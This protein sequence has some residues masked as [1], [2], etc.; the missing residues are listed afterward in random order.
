MHA[1][2]GVTRTPAAAIGSPCPQKPSHSAFPIRGEARTRSRNMLWP[3]L[4]STVS[5]ETPCL[6]H[7]SHR[8]SSNRL[9]SSASC[10]CGCGGEWTSSCG[11]GGVLQRTS[12]ISNALR[13]RSSP[14]TRPLNSTSGLL[15]HTD[16]LRRVAPASRAALAALDGSRGVSGG[17][18]AQQRRRTAPPL[19]CCNLRGFGG[20]CAQLPASPEAPQATGV[21]QGA[22]KRVALQQ[23]FV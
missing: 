21:A 19:L 4:T 16:A 8:Q 12:S 10:C 15:S 9:G 22:S 7:G 17:V 3:V 5:R 18:L 13:T 2:L 1:Q 14:H 20:H 11:L 6:A 23:L